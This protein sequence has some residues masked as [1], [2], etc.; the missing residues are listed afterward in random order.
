[1]PQIPLLQELVRDARE[2]Q[3]AALV[4][5]PTSVGPGYWLAPGVPEAALRSLRAGFAATV[6]DPQFLADAKEIQLAI[7]P[8]SGAEVQAAVQSVAE[9]PPEIRTRTASILGW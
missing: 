5:L 8:R 3:V 7:H 6:A 1:M 9:I 2:R 4:S